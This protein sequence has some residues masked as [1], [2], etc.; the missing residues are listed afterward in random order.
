[1]T[2]PMTS[3]I[4]CRL[5]AVVLALACLTGRAA[6]TDSQTAWRL[7]D[8]IAV[9]YPEAV[10]GGEVVNEFEYAEMLEFSASAGE[11]IGGLE[12][13]PAR[14]GLLDQVRTLRMAIEAKQ[15]PAEVGGLARKAAAALLV[16]YPMPLAPQ[17][18]PDTAR[19]AQLYQQ[20]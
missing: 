1:P 3:K 18:A 20:L 8:Y 14:D 13:T 17:V 19:G 16:A 12:P 9:D 4:L 10:S 6:V 15:P 7:L 5:A 11:L 2:A